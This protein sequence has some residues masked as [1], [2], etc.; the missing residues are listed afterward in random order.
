[1][2]RAALTLAFCLVAWVSGMLG[3]LAGGGGTVRTSLPRPAAGGPP[4]FADI[5][6]RVNPAVVHIAVIEA[7]RSNVH[8]G[9]EDAPELDVPQRGEGSGFIVDPSGYILTNHHLLP[10]P[11]PIPGPLAVQRR[12]PPGPV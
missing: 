6:Q 3:L 7:G 9:V 4:S 5:V 10:P 11:G 12:F 2:T 8:E 1:M